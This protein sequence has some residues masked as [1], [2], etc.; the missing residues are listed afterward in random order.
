VVQAVCADGTCRDEV[1]DGG[2]TAAAFCYSCVTEGDYTYCAEPTDWDRASEVCALLG[3]SLATINTGVENLD[4]GYAAYDYSPEAWWIGFNDRASEG[5]FT[6][7]SG[8]WSPFTMWNFGEPNN[9]GGNEDCATTNY[10]LIGWW[11]DSPCSDLLPFVCEA[12]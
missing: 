1:C 10:P 3:A 7:Q 9:W 4:I 8:L 11:N 2:D 6:W 12:P 5:H